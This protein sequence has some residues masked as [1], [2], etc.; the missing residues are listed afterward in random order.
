MFHLTLLL[1]AKKWQQMHII[2]I[3]LGFLT[4]KAVI[5][6]HILPTAIFLNEKKQS[7]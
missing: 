6:A 7:K 5:I 4:Y 2:P 1:K 3:F